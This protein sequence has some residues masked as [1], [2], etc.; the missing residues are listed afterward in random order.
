MKKEN[1]AQIFWIIWTALWILFALFIAYQILVKVFGGSWISEALTI[2]LLS[3]NLITTI[4]LIQKTARI[5]SDVHHLS[6][7][8]DE[9]DQNLKEHIKESKH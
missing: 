7:K 4:Q 1:I 8:V 2:A 6:R 9:I 5:E 3:A